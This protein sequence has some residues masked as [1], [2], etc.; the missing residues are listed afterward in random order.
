MVIPSLKNITVALALLL[1]AACTGS[2]P[3]PIASFTFHASSPTPVQ[4]AYYAKF[5]RALE[6][7]RSCNSLLSPDGTLHPMPD[8]WLEKIAR[9]EGLPFEYYKSR[10]VPLDFCRPINHVW[11]FPNSHEKFYDAV[12]STYVIEHLNRQ[13][14]A[15]IN[16]VKGRLQPRDREALRW[17]KIGNGIGIFLMRPT[18]FSVSDYYTYQ[19]IN[20]NNG[21]VNPNTG[22]QIAGPNG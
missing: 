10:R 3:S 21:Y 15:D 11:R 5:G 12:T 1:L 22:E 2:R 20:W 13:Q 9:G 18:G 8:S 6:E 16:A 7:P 19:L 4:D 17:M 14:V